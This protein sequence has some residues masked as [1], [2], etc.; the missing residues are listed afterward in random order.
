ML[1]RSL[2][3]QPSII[4]INSRTFLKIKNCPHAPL[5]Q[6]RNKASSPA[7]KPPRPVA[8]TEHLPMFHDK[9]IYLIQEKICIKHTEPRLVCHG[10]QDPELY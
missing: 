8:E 5:S 4:R 3:I 2:T 1:E 9:D 7:A 10:Q 6:F